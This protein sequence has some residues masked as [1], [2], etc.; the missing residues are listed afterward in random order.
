MT[1]LLVH[2]NR[3]A[4]AG[5]LLSVTPESAGW[6]Y[7]GFEVR[8]LKK[9][10][11][12]TLPAA[13]REL[14]VV[15]LSGKTRVRA[16]DFDSGVVGERKCDGRNAVEGPLPDAGPFGMNKRFVDRLCGGLCDCA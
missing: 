14:C 8:A 13:A 16:G 10:Q 2:S 15:V 7:V 3:A 12:F 1:N 6:R 11:R 5:V 9:G 4:A